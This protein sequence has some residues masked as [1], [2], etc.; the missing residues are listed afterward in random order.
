MPNRSSR[1]AIEYVLDKCGFTSA[2]E[3]AFITTNEGLDCWV[4]FTLITFEDLMTIRDNTPFTI[5]AVKL[6]RLTIFEVLN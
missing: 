6:Q 3:R 5:N 4:A 2:A 1:L